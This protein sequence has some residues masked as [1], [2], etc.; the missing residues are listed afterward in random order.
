MKISIYDRINK[1]HTKMTSKKYKKKKKS[2]KFR[3]EGAKRLRKQNR[4][5]FSQNGMEIIHEG[6][7]VTLK[8]VRTPEQHK[9]FIERLKI[10]RPNQLQTI[11]NQ[12]NEA[13]KI[14]EQYDKILL[15][16]AFTYSHLVNQSEDDGL[17]EVTLELGLSFA[18][19]IIGNPV[20]KPNQKVINRLISLLYS[21]RHAYNYYIMSESVTGKYSDIESNIRFSTILEALYVRGDGYSEHIYSVFE[22][23]F[24]GHDKFLME[25]VGFSSKDVLSTILQLEDSFYCR[26]LYPNGLP[27]PAAHTRFVEWSKSQ[28]AKTKKILDRNMIDSFG[29]DN[30]DLIIK[31]SKIHGYKIDDLSEYYELFKIRYRTE[32]QKKVVEA[33]SQCFGN[34]A[35]FLNPQF[36]G[37][38][39]N[40][41]TISTLPIIKLKSDY[42]LFSFALPTRNLFDILE[43]LIKTTDLNYYNSNYLSNKYQHSRDNYLEIKASK[44][45]KKLIPNSFSY[46]NVKYKTNADSNDDRPYEAELDLLVASESA[47]YLIEIKA[48]GLSTPS[49]RGALKS[50]L[51]QLKEIVGYGA[52]QNYKAL[53]YIKKNEN[54]IFI[55]SDG[56]KIQVDKSKKTFR[57]LITLDHLAGLVANM[58]DLKELGVIEKEVEF[59]WTCSMFDLIIFSEI[60]ENENDFID[61]LEKRIPLYKMPKIDPQDEIN[62]LGYFLEHNLVFDEEKLKDLTTLQLQKFT[63]KID[64]YFERRSSKPK[65]IIK[66]SS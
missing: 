58:F 48:G 55:N 13:I 60:I 52:Y 6:K 7:N 12:I 22:E 40:N 32:I 20:E 45:F 31:N 50:L 44:L 49:K 65:R 3:K 47:N 43:S 11:N 54:P 10:N 29:E 63:S 5:I 25:K 28:M 38:P 59:A 4:E 21:I 16:G 39:L 23:L 17:S 19:A 66:N 61:Y 8:N 24:S 2:R 33:I 62:L 35:E 15:L 18:T 64:A 27:H 34:N 37:L 41:T 36:K 51:G 46:S 9:E 26:F 30:A 42:Y 56:S 53:E 14:F 1:A 57:I